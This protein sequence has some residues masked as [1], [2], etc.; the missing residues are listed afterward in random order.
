[1]SITMKCYLLCVVIITALLLGGCWRTT[2]ETDPAAISTGDLWFGKD[3]L[4]SYLVSRQQEL[5]L[6][7]EKTAELAARLEQ[8]QQAL[9]LLD[10]EMGSEAS[11]DAAAQ[12]ARKDIV[13]EAGKQQQLL[14]ARQKELGELRANVARLKQQLAGAAEGERRRLTEEI[15]ACEIALED[16][17][18]AVVRLERS[19][20]KVLSAG[21]A[22]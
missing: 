11:L 2:N 5:T 10:K 19:I 1:M 14:Q 22:L 17:E 4:D 20:T 18:K 12:A 15:V 21:K 6:L 7:E 3:R 9:L 13:R 8:R 16:L